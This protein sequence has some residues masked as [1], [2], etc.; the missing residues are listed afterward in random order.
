M[1]RI[2]P[3]T[4]L[5]LF[6]SALLAEQP[7]RYWPKWRGAA[8]AGSTS[9]GNYA[10]KFSGT[11]NLEWKTELPGKGCSTPIVWGENILLTCPVDG[12]DAVLSFDWSGKKRWQTT[13]G[14]ERRGKHRNGSGSNPSVITDDGK[15][16]FVYFKSSNLA[17]VSIDG[18]VL[19]KQNLQKK[20]ARD[21]L[22]WDLGTSPVLTKDYVVIATLHA[23]ESYLVAFERKTGKQAWYISRNY[24]TPTEGDHSYSTPHVIERDGK[25]IIVVWGAEHL[26]G[27]DA[28]DGS[29]I[30][31]AGD[32]NPTGKRNWVTVASTVIAGDMV[33]IPYGRGSR[34]AGVKLNGKGDVTKSHRPWTRQD[35]GAFVPT[36]AVHDGKVYMLRDRGEV[37]CVDPSNGKTVW[38]GKLPKKGS[39]YYSSPTVADGKIYC[40]R[41]D[42]VIFVATANEKFELL[43]ENNMGER[44]IASPVPVANRL[45]LRGEKHLFCVNAPKD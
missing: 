16:L 21:T 43:S 29:I 27:H 37:V 8:D 9:L 20:Y 18:Q 2:L 44:V 39:S 33:V 7:D 30:W 25:E 34:L 12:K 36:P 31:S 26:T 4:L 5:L 3:I 41:E 22:Y 1:N 19:W 24:K 10:A 15:N 13:I 45:L 28:T 32:F 6:A 35:T 17:C 40:T 38:S 23:G 11:D 14:E 42:G